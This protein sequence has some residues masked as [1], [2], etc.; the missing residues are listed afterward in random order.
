MSCIKRIKPLYSS[1]MVRSFFT[2][3]LF[4][5]ASLS[6]AGLLLRP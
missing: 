3:E 1:A 2:N 5:L 6:L 4:L